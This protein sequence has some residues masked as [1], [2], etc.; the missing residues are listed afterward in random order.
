MPLKRKRKTKPT[1]ALAESVTNNLSHWT[2][3]P[4][5]F[6]YRSKHNR[7]M[8]QMHSCDLN[9]EAPAVVLFYQLLIYF[10]HRRDTDLIRSRFL[11]VIFFNLREALGVQRFRSRATIGLITQ[12][13]SASQFIDTPS[14]NIQ[15][16]IKDWCNEGKKLDYLCRDVYGN[17]HGGRRYLGI[18]FSL[19]QDVGKE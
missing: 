17:V 1:I 3:N 2:Q 11:K 7:P 4:R 19:P 6:L 12:I 14:E 10:E 8:D 13:L 18:L 15:S 5:D 9:W 16:R